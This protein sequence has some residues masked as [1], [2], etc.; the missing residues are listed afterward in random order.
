MISVILDANALIMPFQFGLNLDF[1]LER[2]FGNHEIY[3]PSSVMNE[4]RGLG[5]K[6]AL[7]LSKKYNKIKVTKKGDEGVLEAA[8][9]LDGVIVTNDKELKKRALKNNFSVAYLRSRSH[10]QLIGEKIYTGSDKV[11]KEEIV[12]KGKITS[13]I[14]EGKFFLSLEGY[15]RQLK[16]KFNMEPF[17]GTLNVEIVED[18][19]GD[20]EDLK[21]KQGMMLQ[22]FEKDGKNFGPVKCFDCTIDDTDCFLIMP[23]KSRYENVAEIISKHE[24]R[25]KLGLKDGDQIRLIITL[26]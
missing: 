17:E 1:E 9:K 23:E 16:E 6:D 21:G 14:G 18:Y 26:K 5:R 4:L 22:G 10:L 24:L 20:Y 7:S 8:K 3:V 2:L 12:L 25:E 13:G 15:R 19:L 11:K